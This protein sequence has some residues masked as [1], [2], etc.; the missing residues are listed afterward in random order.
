MREYWYLS[1]EVKAVFPFSL[2]NVIGMTMKY[3]HLIYWD[4]VLYI[5]VVDIRIMD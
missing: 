5:I 4:E 1:N 2:A 3:M